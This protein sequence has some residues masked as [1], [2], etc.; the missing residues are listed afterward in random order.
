MSNSEIDLP[1]VRTSPVVISAVVAA[2]VVAIGTTVKT[3]LY[4]Y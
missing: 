3:E 1:T 4:I 2:V